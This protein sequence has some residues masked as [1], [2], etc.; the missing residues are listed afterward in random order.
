MAP[1]AGTGRYKATELA[2][3]GFAL[4]GYGD[5]LG[6]GFAPSGYLVRTD[7]LGN[8]MWARSIS[9]GNGVDEAYC[10]SGSQQR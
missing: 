4:V 5:A 2:D 9:S 8:E 6:T 1:Q 3:G 7:A 10:V